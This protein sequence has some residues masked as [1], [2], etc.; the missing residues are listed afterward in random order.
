MLFSFLRLERDLVRENGRLGLQQDENLQDSVC[1]KI[2]A[3]GTC[4][5]HKREREKSYLT[6]SGTDAL[7]EDEV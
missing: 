7:W 3:R 5:S 1:N 2:L 6:L 4:K